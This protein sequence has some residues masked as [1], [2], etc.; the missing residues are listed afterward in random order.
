[1]DTLASFFT[2]WGYKAAWT[3]YNSKNEPRMAEVDAFARSLFIYGQSVFDTEV[4][5][6]LNPQFS[7]DTFGKALTHHMNSTH[8]LPGASEAMLMQNATR[9][10]DLISE[11]LGDGP[12]VT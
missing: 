10:A 12:A 4:T 3:A 1:M 11:F 9:I 6:G 2:N 8:W 7:L 5:Y